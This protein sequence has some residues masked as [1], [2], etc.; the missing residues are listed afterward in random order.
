MSAGTVSTTRLR[1]NT[2][3]CYNVIKASPERVTVYRKYP[4]HDRDVL[5]SF[6]P[7]SCAYEK[8]ESLLGDVTRG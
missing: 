6:S 2:K 1:G 8:P 4:F 3:P 7:A 5:V